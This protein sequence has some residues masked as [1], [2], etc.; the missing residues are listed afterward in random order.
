MARWEKGKSGNPGGRPKGEG[1]IRELARQHTPQAIRRLARVMNDDNAPPS[2]QVAAS[3]ALLDRGWG[4]PTQSIS[5]TLDANRPSVS[6]SLEFRA[7][8]LLKQV[9][10][11]PVDAAALD[12]EQEDQ[13]PE[14]T[15]GTEEESST[16]PTAAPG[17]H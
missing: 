7:I 10:G 15:H 8:D 12:L 13:R 2:A 5:A 6:E 3:T 14:I 4:R 17:T 16:P 11:E 1:D 9:R